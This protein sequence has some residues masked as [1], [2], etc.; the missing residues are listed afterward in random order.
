MCIWTD[1][2]L[3]GMCGLK[4]FR[5]HQD[6]E[7]E[8]EREEWYKSVEANEQWSQ[9]SLG[10]CAKTDMRVGVNVYN[11]H[12]Y[13]YWIIH[14]FLGFCYLVVFFS[15]RFVRLLIRT[16]SHHDSMAKSAKSLTR[17]YARIKAKDLLGCVAIACAAVVVFLFCLSS[18]LSICVAFWFVW[19][20]WQ[21]PSANKE[22]LTSVLW[23]SHKTA[24]WKCI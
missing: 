2:V 4:E 24:V 19:C 17:S 10:L 23:A 6:R 20:I 1:R 15:F 7:R 22:W 3:Q 14:F 12:M 16:C 5:T 11:L 9:S 21:M 18:V 8:R 13:S